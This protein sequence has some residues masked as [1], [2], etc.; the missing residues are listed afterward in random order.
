MESLFL[1]LFLTLGKWSAFLPTPRGPAFS[2]RGVGVCG[3]TV[4]IALLGEEK[5]KTTRT[6]KNLTGL[7]EEA[8]EPVVMVTLCRG[9]GHGATVGRPFAFPLFVC[10]KNLKCF[11]CNDAVYM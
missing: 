11:L 3:N 6:D 1:N 2:G 8:V 4:L 7:T 10:G 9:V 5:L